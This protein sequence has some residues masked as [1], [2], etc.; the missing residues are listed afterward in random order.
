MQL[1]CPSFD[2]GASPKFSS[3]IPERKRKKAKKKKNTKLKVEERQHQRARTQ[4]SHT[5]PLPQLLPAMSAFK[6]PYNA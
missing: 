2:A 6:A 5:Q 3:S 4:D 1:Y